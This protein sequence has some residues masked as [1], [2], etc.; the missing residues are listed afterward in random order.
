[1]SKS[2][3]NRAI[4]VE[5]CL[6]FLM[7]V[8]QEIVDDGAKSVGIITNH[9]HRGEQD[10]VVVAICWPGLDTEDNRTIKFFCP[11][12]DKAGHTAHQANKGVTVVLTR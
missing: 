1:M 5:A 4:R 7:K 11:S 6:R 3:N 8:I 9:G 12:I 2:E 10:H